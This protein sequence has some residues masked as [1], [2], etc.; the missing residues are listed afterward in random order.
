MVTRLILC[1]ILAVPAMAETIVLGNV[2]DTAWTWDGTRFI[3]AWGAQ[4]SWTPASL[5]P[6]AW[7]RMDDN[8]GS[9]VVIDSVGLNTATAYRNTADTHTDGVNGGALGFDGSSDY[10]SLP[11][12]VSVSELGL[13]GTISMWIKRSE[14]DLYP[15]VYED[16]DSVSGVNGLFFR[17][18]GTGVIVFAGVDDGNYMF[19]LFGELTTTDWHLVTGSITPGSVKLYI[20]GVL[21]ASGDVSIANTYYPTV[22]VGHDMAT[23]YF[24]YFTG[25]VDDVLIFNRVLTAPEI[26][27]LYNW[28]Q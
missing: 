9:A 8:A 1:L 11:P 28:R 5:G 15:V 25:A 22:N 16:Y 10:V 3:A 6:V 17:P 13:T 18:F 21:A 26:M 20:D 7:Y 27:Q 24:S 2:E 23:G 14:L 19:A 12:S 4:E